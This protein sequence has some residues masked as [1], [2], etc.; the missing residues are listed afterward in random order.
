MGAKPPGSV[1]TLANH[2]PGSWAEGPHEGD[3]LE[4]RTGR[5]YLITD[6]RKVGDRAS[7]TCVVMHPDDPYPDQAVRFSWEWTPRR[8]RR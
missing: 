4:T 2:R 7:Y 3:V 6:R 5:R 1:V 8:R